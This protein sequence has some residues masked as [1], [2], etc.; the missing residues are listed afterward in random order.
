MQLKRLVQSGIP[1]HLRGN[2]W[3]RFLDVPTRCHSRSGLYC[4]LVRHSLGE[5]AAE[6]LAACSTAHSHTSA[7]SSSYN[8]VR[9]AGRDPFATVSN[10]RILCTSDAE[11]MAQWVGLKALRMFAQCHELTIHAPC[12]DDPAAGLLPPQ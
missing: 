2:I 11:L 7:C 3:Q 5:E 12:S 10:V 8:D 4:K 9:Q 1:A 6:F